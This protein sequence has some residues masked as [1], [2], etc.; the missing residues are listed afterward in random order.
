MCMH[1]APEGSEEGHQ[2]PGAERTGGPEPPDV[3]AEKRI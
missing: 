2:I 3:G 1:A